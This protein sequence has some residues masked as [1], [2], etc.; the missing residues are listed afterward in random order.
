MSIDQY[1]AARSSLGVIRQD[2]MGLLRLT[3]S[4]RQA[5]LQGMVT[6]DV[7]KL[8]SG[9]GCYAAH[10]NAQGK[11]VAQMIILATESETLLLV[12][13]VAAEKLAT[14]F[15]KLIIMEDA[16]IHNASDEYDVITLM[17][18]EARPLLE[19]WGVTVSA[20]KLYSH[21]SVPQGRVVFS[22]LGSQIIVPREFSSSVMK[23]L[24]AGG[25][26]EIDRSTWDVLRTE[27]GLPLYGVD[28][29]ETT[30]FPELG[31]RGI[32]YDKGCYIGQEVV[33]RIKY[34]GHVN[35]QFVG[36]VAAASE[37]PEIRS[38]VMA[39]GKEV[40]YVTSAVFS[41]TLKKAIALG[42]VARAAA[43]P[44]TEVTLVGKG[45]GGIT[46]RV[47]VLPLV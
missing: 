37:I 30:T 6:N 18:P 44:D 14:A 41:P 34:I 35:R 31:Q 21:F 17:G 2:W 4:E 29:D 38:I 27:E 28:I 24:F 9:E 3:G 20:P 42:F 5:W 39:R 23:S 13:R 15:D 22:D 43:E 11:I 19:A 16:Q 10:L 7:V 1:N 32:S 26:T 8:G 33:A 45:G 47:S 25:A 40:G 12:E 36:F 46:A